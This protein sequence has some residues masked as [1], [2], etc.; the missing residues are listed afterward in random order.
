MLFIT[1]AAVS[2]ELYG[3]MQAP[4]AKDIDD[5]PAYYT[6]WAKISGDLHP[7]PVPLDY[8]DCKIFDIMSKN[9]L[10]IS[11]NAWSIH[12]VRF[13]QGKRP[14][15]DAASGRYIWD[16]IELYKHDDDCS[17]EELE[18]VYVKIFK[19]LKTGWYPST[20][21][22]NQ[23]IMFKQPEKNWLLFIKKQCLVEEDSLIRFL[24]RKFNLDTKVDAMCEWW[25]NPFLVEERGL[26]YLWIRKD[27]LE[28]VQKKFKFRISVSK[29]DEDDQKEC[30]EPA[31]KK[32]RREIC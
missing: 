20:I 1:V 31:A 32:T 4:P 16:C 26:P 30:D 12:D 6:Y 14:V 27:A 10:K 17:A 28:D 19:L 25:K 3:A 11:K 15:I 22:K 23:D 18:E 24:A 5:L 8:C 13:G 21:K 29:R 2:A 7:S 9:A